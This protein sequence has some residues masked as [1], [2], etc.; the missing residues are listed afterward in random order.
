MLFRDDIVENMR[1]IADLRM[2]DLLS[3]EEFLGR[4]EE[5]MREFRSARGM[6]QAPAAPPIP[7]APPLSPD[8]SL[9]ALHIHSPTGNQQRSEFTIR[10][11]TIGRSSENDLIL[12]RNDI[13]RCHA[14]ILMRDGRFI[15]L[16]LKSENG[17]Y[18]NG[19]KIG[20]PQ[21]VQPGERI[22]IGDYELFIE[23][24]HSTEPI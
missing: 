6:P 20:S 15:V 18:V 13:S 21:V 16:D 5:L 3:D 2:A 7:E 14:R 8:T 9:F 22:S 11:I 23:A 10:E 19:R 12:R 1:L 17:T 24:L 4:M